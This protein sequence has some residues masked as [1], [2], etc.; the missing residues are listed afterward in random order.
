[1]RKWRSDV[2]FSRRC[3][4]V[5]FGLGALLVGECNRL[6][7]LQACSP[8]PFSL[9]H[10]DAELSA[11]NATVMCFFDQSSSSVTGRVF[12]VC[13]QGIFALV[14]LGRVE[15]YVLP[16]CVRRM[17]FWEAY[18]IRWPVGGFSC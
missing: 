12:A 14:C 17:V 15:Q 16:S 11:E 9:R 13:S 1:M 6:F 18:W 2:F 8:M 4:L 5:S 7:L 3:T 10:G